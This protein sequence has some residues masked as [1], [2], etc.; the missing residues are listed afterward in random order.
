MILIS[1]PFRRSEQIWADTPEPAGRRNGAKALDLAE[2]T[3]ADQMHP[4]LWPAVERL[5]RSDNAAAIRQHREHST[6]GLPPSGT[7]AGGSLMV[8]NLL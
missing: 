3:R 1:P 8:M 2:R 7:E 6:W 4:V 5:N